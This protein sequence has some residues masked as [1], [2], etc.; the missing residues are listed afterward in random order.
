MLERQTHPFKPYIIP[1]YARG[2]IIGSAPPNQFCTGKPRKLR[3]GEINFFYGSLEN[4]FWYLLKN[5]L[6][7]YQIYWPRNSAHCEKLLRDHSLGIGDILLSFDRR[8]DGAA[9]TDLSNFEHNEE[10]ITS[11]MK[12]CKTRKT[13][14]HLFFTSKFAYDQFVNA[15]NHFGYTQGPQENDT[16]G[17][18]AT[19]TKNKSSKRFYFRILISPS[20]AAVQSLD[21]KAKDYCAK[22][23]NF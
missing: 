17:F 10:L 19:I 22:F 23:W 1:D 14:D 12:N 21:L 18:S 5:A 3:E 20:P 4:Q 7:P 15:I 11:I 16:I 13:I 8:D 6:D 9:D 2:V